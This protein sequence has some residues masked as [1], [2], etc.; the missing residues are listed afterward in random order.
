MT[1]AEGLRCRTIQGDPQPWLALI[2]RLGRLK[3]HLLV[4][5]PSNVAVDNI[6][7]RVMQVG[8]IDSSGGQY[9]PALLRLGSGK[10]ERVKCVSLEDIVEQ[11]GCVVQ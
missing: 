6:V 3:P 2:S 11:V 10:A 8:F 9:K 7:E 4:T 1:G 5:A